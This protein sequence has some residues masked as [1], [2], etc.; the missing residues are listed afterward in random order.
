MKG[1]R[2]A[3][4]RWTDTDLMIYAAKR[5]SADLQQAH[6]EAAEALRE[7]VESILALVAFVAVWLV[8]WI[9]L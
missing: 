7:K 8:A 3:N 6:A 2:R 9:V 1:Y 5:R 4:R